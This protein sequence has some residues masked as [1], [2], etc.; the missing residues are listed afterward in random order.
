[1]KER[2]G[3]RGR[4]C[5]VDTAERCDREGMEA[6]IKGSEAVLVFLFKGTLDR[7]YCRFEMRLARA[8]GVPVIIMLEGD[9]Y[10]EAY[11]S[12]IDVLKQFD[13]VT[14]PSDLRCVAENVDFNF[15]YR[16]QEHEVDGM[17]N[18][19]GEKIDEPQA[20]GTWPLN[21]ENKSEESIRSEVA[22]A[23]WL[24]DAGLGAEL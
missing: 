2:L 22:E 21:R 20:E 15:F 10:R 13:D 5:W 23:F 4:K 12:I 16:R 14:L 24:L 3:R 7:P 6:G 1:M 18:R 19:L 11:V 9:H 17:L 8:Y